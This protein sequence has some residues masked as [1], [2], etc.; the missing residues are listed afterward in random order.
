MSWAVVL[1]ASAGTGAAV[2]SSLARRSQLDIF[3]VH[4][5]NHAESAVAVCAEVQ[6]AGRACHMRVAD[7]G[8]YDGAQL[9][10]DEIVA[11]CGRQSVSFFVHSIA[12]ASVARLVAGEGPPPAHP[13]QVERTFEA[14]AHSFVWWCQALLEHDLL[15]PGARL[16][17]LSNPMVDQVL[18]GTALVAA[19]K[20]ALSTYVRH[21]AHEMGPLGYRVN[22]LK[23]GAVPTH[24]L[25]TT[26]GSGPASAIADTAARA[27]PAGRLVTLPEVADFVALLA[28][29]EAAWLNGAT[30]DFTGGETQ[31]L[32]DHAV[33]VYSPHP[34]EAVPCPPLKA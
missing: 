8:T 24:A 19:S 27:I 11:V 25:L 23:F 12:C 32:Y 4:R 14:M 31:A 1:G 30:L 7:A 15:A 26:V 29:P 21:L 13:K 6:T 20:A 18:R 2:A 3:G 28:R 5:G 9:G 10:A 16:L 17:A 33:H 34:P 22:E